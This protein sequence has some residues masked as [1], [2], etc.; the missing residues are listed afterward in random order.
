MLERLGNLGASILLG[1][2]VPALAD[3]RSPTVRKCLVL[4]REVLAKYGKLSCFEDVL[5]V[6]GCAELGKSDVEA[7]LVDTTAAFDK[8]VQV[9]KTQ[10]YLDFH[11]REEVRPISIGG[12]QELISAGN[13]REAVPFIMVMFNRSIL[14]IQ[15][16]APED[17]KLPFLASYQKALDVLGLGTERDF[18][19]RVDQWKETLNEIWDITGE[20]LDMNPEI[21]D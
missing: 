15:N 19:H 21:R 3:L 10:F 9:I 1:V 18:F 12:S 20:I 13:H 17:E 2:S 8:A 11:I 4:Y 16:D 5:T 7:L 14:A 6:L